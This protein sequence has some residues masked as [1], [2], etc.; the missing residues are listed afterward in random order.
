MAESS[1]SFTRASAAYERVMV[2][3]VFGSRAK[4]LLDTAALAYGMK[5]LDVACGTG[6]VARLAARQ[7]GPSGHVSE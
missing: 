5:A 6:I 1:S 3:A 7:V 4:D 2:P